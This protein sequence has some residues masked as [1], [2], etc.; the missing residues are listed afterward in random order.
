MSHKPYFDKIFDFSIAPAKKLFNSSYL[1][2]LTGLLV[3]M[4]SRITQEYFFEDDYFVN[5]PS[6]PNCNYKESNKEISICGNYL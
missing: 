4:T 6:L 3:N 2:E 1:E 5:H